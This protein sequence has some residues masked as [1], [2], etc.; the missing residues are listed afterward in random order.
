MPH[1]HIPPPWSLPESQTTPERVYFS[2]RQVLKGL[3]GLSTAIVTPSLVGCQTA[4]ADPLAQSLDRPN[5]KD[6]GKNPE[7]TTLD[8]PLT[9]PLL[10]GQYNNF[11]EFG[12]TKSIWRAAQALPTEPWTIEVG[13]LVNNPKTY[14]L[15]DLR[16]SFSLEERPY[17]FRCVEAWSMALPWVGFPMRKLLEA[18]D[19]QPEAQF[20]RFTSY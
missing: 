7:F 10:A 14:D 6:Y 2:R 20:V 5:L 15:D 3:L 13:G 11:Y 18:A 4:T 16:R 17:R 1:L 12:G 9:D 19:P 8:R